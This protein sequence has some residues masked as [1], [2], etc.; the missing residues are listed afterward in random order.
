MNIYIITIFYLLDQ[1]LR[2][3]L[4]PPTMFVDVSHLRGLSA[5]LSL[6]GSIQVWTSLWPFNLHMAP[7]LSL[8]VFLPLLSALFDSTIIMPVFL[9]ISID[10]V[11][12]FQLFIVGLSEPFLGEC[13]FDVHDGVFGFTRCEISD[14]NCQNWALEI[15]WDLMFQFPALQC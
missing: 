3:V 10:L 12:C 14:S 2:G 8:I 4:N 15:C 7:L 9:L 13:V 1:L 6:S 11:S 5:L